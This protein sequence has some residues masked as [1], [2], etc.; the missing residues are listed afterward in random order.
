MR[1]CGYYKPVKETHHRGGSFSFGTIERC[2]LCIGINTSFHARKAK[3]EDILPVWS[4]M[5][6]ILA[7]SCASLLTHLRD[8]LAKP[9][10]ILV[11]HV[12]RMIP[13]NRTHR[14]AMSIPGRYGGETVIFR[15]SDCNVIHKVVK[16]S[17]GN[18]IPILFTCLPS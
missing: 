13:K 2:I 18:V 6:E 12:R 3:L 11:I 9:R 5:V 1:F 14:T 15:K 7:D 17:G 16:A 8:L 4:G 10:R